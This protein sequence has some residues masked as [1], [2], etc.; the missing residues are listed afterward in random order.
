MKGS[1]DYTHKTRD[2]KD[3]DTKEN[4]DEE[5]EKE[6]E[7]EEKE[8]KCYSKEL[9]D[10]LEVKSCLVGVLPAD[11]FEFPH[12][13]VLRRKILIK[14]LSDREVMFKIRVSCLVSYRVKPVFGL[15]APEGTYKVMI[16]HLVS[17]KKHDKIFIVNTFAPKGTHEKQLPQIFRALEPVGFNREINLFAV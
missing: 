1:R 6:E 10:I 2:T 9:D 17:E 4:E 5:K 11:E 14:N 3:T 16:T 15:L 13:R 12:D 8:V 7:K